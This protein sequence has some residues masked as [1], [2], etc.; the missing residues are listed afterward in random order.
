MADSERYTVIFDPHPR[1][2]ELI[3]TPADWATLNERYSLIEPPSINNVSFYEEHIQSARYIIGQPPL[4]TELLTKASKLRAVFNVEGNFLDNMDYDLCFERGIHILATSPVFAV[5]VAELGIG[6]ALSL[7]RNI[8]TA[9]QAFRTGSEKYGLDSNNHAS[10]LTEA[11]VGFIGFGDLGVALHTLLAGFNC[12][13]SVYDPWL[14][15]SLI[16]RAGARVATLADVLKASDVIFVVAAVTDSNAGYLGAAEF[17]SMRKGASL[18]LL[19]RAGVVDFPEMVAAVSSG[20]IRVA[21]DVFPE[22]PLAHDDPLREVP[23]LILSAHRAGALDSAFKAMGRIVLEDMQ[24]L[25]CNLAPR[26]CKRA[27]RET[28][29]RLRSVPVSTN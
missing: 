19:S 14:P 17:S 21:T 9:D 1:T 18:I 10:L 15:D 8:P 25:D 12:N 16:S 2:A 22:E 7:L 27:E 29:S 24:L 4:S 26:L 23:G 3:F 11:N 6:L 5:P 13:I 28:V 20:H